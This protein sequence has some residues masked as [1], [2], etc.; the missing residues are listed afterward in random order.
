MKLHL[1][2]SEIEPVAAIPI[3][4]KLSRSNGNHERTWFFVSRRITR[5]SF[6]KTRKHFLRNIL[7]GC[8]FF[9]RF[10]VFAIQET[11]LSASIFVSKKQYQIF[12]FRYTAENFEREC[13]RACVVRASEHL[14]KFLQA[15]SVEK[16]PNFGRTFKRNGT[17]RY[18]YYVWPPNLPLSIL[19][20]APDW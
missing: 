12:C 3:S 2:A 17:I 4:V 13:E 14:P 9:Q 15:I 18:P 20:K 5:V 10:P 11:L 7:S 1:E 8:M 6:Y 16:G 19:P